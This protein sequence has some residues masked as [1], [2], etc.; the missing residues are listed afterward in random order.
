MSSSF[1]PPLDFRARSA[2]CVGMV[3]VDLDDD[4]ALLAAAASAIGRRG[5][6]ARQARLSPEEK[7]EYGRWLNRL[8]WKGHKAKRPASSR[9]RPS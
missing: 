2:Y 4:E 6:R 9:K 8:R 5:G 7:S 1:S 3:K